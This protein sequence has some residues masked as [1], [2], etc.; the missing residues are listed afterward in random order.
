MA[1]DPSHVEVWLYGQ[2]GLGIVYIIKELWRISKDQSHKNTEDIGKLMIQQAK[3]QQD[4]NAAWERVRMLEKAA[5][6][7]R[8]RNPGN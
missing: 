2:L 3:S 6:R 1:V 5:S 8:Q 4:L 7:T